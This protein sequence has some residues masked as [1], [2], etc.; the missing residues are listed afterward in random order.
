MR[1]IEEFNK[2]KIELKYEKGKKNVFADA[3]SRL[4]SKN[5]EEIVQCVNAILA[6]F[7]PKDLD[8][9]EGIIKYFTKNYQV[10]DGTLYYKKN[11]DLYLKVIYK[12]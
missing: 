12:R 11:D 10:V 2:Y 3:L 6:D 8:L 5:S 7:N 1:W 4:P 9:P